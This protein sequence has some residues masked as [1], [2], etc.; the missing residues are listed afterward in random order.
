MKLIEDVSHLKFDTYRK[1][2]LTRARVLTETDYQER[3]GKIETL[4]GPQSFKPGD[5]L[6][7]GVEN[8]EWPI[9]AEKM[10]TSKQQVGESDTEGWADYV[11][12]GEVQATQIFE[13]FQVKRS[14]GEMYTGK[15]GDYLI[16]DGDN[17]RIVAQG[18]FRKS[19][20]R[21]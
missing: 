10:F 21:I 4:E 19:Y 15:A 11:T 18:I 14:N 1:A 20:E 6:S 9:R 8:E 17:K 3:G 12:K 16:V 7:R 5:F 2:A 13:P